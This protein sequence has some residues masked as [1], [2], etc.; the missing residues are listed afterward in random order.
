MQ[1]GIRQWFTDV[2][3]GVYYKRTNF[4]DGPVRQFAGIEISLPIGPGRDMQVTGT[5]RF[6]YAVETVIRGDGV[7]PV[8]TGLGMLPPR[9][10]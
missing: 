1:L 9:L 4:T 10:R 3:V 7:N 8:I 6:R 5:R 2:T